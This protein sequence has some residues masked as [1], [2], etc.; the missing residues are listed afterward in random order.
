MA[1]EYYGDATSTTTAVAVVAA[2]LYTRLASV[3][4]VCTM[5]AS[6]VHGTLLVVD[7]VEAATTTT[8]YCTAVISGTVTHSH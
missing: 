4:C 7:I 8:A 6:Q 1:A 5:L 3:V 2:V